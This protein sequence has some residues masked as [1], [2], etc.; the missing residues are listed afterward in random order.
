MC[1][2]YY[3]SK[4]GKANLERRFSFISL[5]TKTGDIFPG[6]DALII[7]PQGKQL[8]C[9]PWHWGKDRI[10]NARMET[11]FTKPTF[12]EAILKNRCVIPADAFYEWDAFK[13]K[14]KFDIGIKHTSVLCRYY[15]C[16]IK[17][18]DFTE[19]L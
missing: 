7:K 3:L 17:S 18:H 10:I 13:Q 1:G 19:R 6:Q 4:E 12:K 2:C 11:I 16:F 8:I 14:V 5:H 15:L 9:V